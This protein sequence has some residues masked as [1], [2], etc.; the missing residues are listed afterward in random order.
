MNETMRTIHSL[1]SIH[2]NFSP[3]DISDDDLEQI[4][5]AAEK[6]ANA[7]ARQNYAILVLDGRSGMREL[8]GC[9]GSRALVFCVDFLRIRMTGDRLGHKYDGAN[10]INFITGIVDASLA[11]QAAVIAA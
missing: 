8:F 5:T 1:R 7:S 6:A 11:V 9:E 4:L 10:I 2:G 3:Q